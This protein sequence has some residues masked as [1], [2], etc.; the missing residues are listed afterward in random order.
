MGRR[1]NQRNLKTAAAAARAAA[2]RRGIF[3]RMH[4]CMALVVRVPMQE[5][6]TGKALTR[7]KGVGTDDDADN[8]VTQVRF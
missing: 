1:R 6:S 3:A 8:R 2:G 7:E 4:A 5:R